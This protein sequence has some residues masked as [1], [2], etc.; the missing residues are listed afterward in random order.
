MTVSNSNS[1]ATGHVSSGGGSCKAAGEEEAAAGE[2]AE[3]LVIVCVDTEVGGGEA[4][5]AEAEIAGE[6]RW[7]KGYGLE[8]N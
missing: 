5:D 7:I 4:A 1:G 3:S 6:V 2:N 8:C